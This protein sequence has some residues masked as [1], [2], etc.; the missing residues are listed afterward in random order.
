MQRGDKNT[1]AVIQAWCYWCYADEIYHER[2]I[3]YALYLSR[4]RNS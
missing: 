3:N 2:I 4:W 1:A